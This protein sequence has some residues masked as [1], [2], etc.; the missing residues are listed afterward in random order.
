MVALRGPKLKGSMAP[1]LPVKYGEDAR[2]GAVTAVP[3]SEI[4]RVSR[5]SA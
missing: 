2:Y 3:L 1:D 4:K 5:E